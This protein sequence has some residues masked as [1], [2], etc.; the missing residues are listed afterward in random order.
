MPRQSFL[1]VIETTHNAPVPH[2]KEAIERSLEE[3]PSIG[4]EFDLD[5]TDIDVHEYNE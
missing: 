3:L 4:E 2:V 5:V 1:V